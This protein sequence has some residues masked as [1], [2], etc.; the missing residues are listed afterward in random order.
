MLI[1][2]FKQFQ[3]DKIQ[4]T[5]FRQIVFNKTINVTFKLYWNFLALPQNTNWINNLQTFR[6]F[7]Q[8]LTK[9]NN[10]SRL[11]TIVFKFQPFPCFQIQWES[12]YRIY[13]VPSFTTI[14]VTL[15]RCIYPIVHIVRP[16]L[17][18]TL[19]VVTGCNHSGNPCYCYH[20][21]CVVN[22]STDTVIA[23]CRC[24]TL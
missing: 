4:P 5:H 12:Y 24:A 17:C 18:A 19:E 10:V 9:F 1:W 16:S 21:S 3:R 7:Y 11:W 2:T 13:Y 20:L 22:H 8:I 15:T 23:V 14:N 6:T